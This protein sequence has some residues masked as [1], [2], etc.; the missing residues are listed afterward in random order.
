MGFFKS[1]A[2]GARNV[3]GGTSKPA[4]SAS[5]P[6]SA[7]FPPVGEATFTLVADENRPLPRTKSGAEEEADVMRVLRGD[8]LPTTP[9]LGEQES[10][11]EATL[12]AA[13]STQAELDF[14]GGEVLYVKS[15][16][17]YYFQY[18]FAH[19]DGSPQNELIVGFLDGSA[20]LYQDI[21]IDEASAFYHAS[22]P[23]GEVWNRLRL[24]G[25]VYGHQKDY[26]LIE[27]HRV[28]HAAG[29]DSISRHEA[30][31][32]SGEP[33]KGFHSSLNYKGAKGAMGAVGGGVSLG[34]RGGSKKVAHFL[35][36]R[37]K[38]KFGPRP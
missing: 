6:R 16:N 37:A 31:P 29:A 17:V 32:K 4:K 7:S 19:P 38:P 14:L 27:G 20:Y 36:S 8:Q 15:S 2:R 22:S 25:T 3:F 11:A 34:K 33:F 12:K 10:E 24:R 9:T 26:R 1:L 23:G 35:S 5:I 30:I 28:W 13:A 21:S 18:L